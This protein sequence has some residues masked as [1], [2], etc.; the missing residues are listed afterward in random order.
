MI[1]QLK[2]LD[3]QSE[4]GDKSRREDGLGDP[5]GATIT[6]TSAPDPPPRYHQKRKNK[7]SKNKNGQSYVR[8]SK[9]AK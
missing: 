2:L 3:Y 8:E 1:T 9:N 4:Q 5:H 7:R 6:P